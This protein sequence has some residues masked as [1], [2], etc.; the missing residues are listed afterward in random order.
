MQLTHLQVFPSNHCEFLIIIGCTGISH[1]HY[2]STS[3]PEF[4]QEASLR[5]L[6]PLLPLHP[7]ST[8]TSVAFNWIC[9]DVTTSTQVTIMWGTWQI[10][11]WTTR[12][13]WK[14]SAQKVKN[15]GQNNTKISE[16]N[17]LTRHRHNPKNNVKHQD[18]LRVCDKGWFIIWIFC[19]T[20]STVWGIFMLN[21]T[22]KCYCSYSI[23]CMSRILSALRYADYKPDSNGRVWITGPSM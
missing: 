16:Q 19:W 2:F 21:T 14:V 5:T 12:T 3:W 11:L 15:E 9:R 20:S 17:I 22:V 1:L 8:S 18:S 13:R 23:H 4:I 6:K 7:H 10:T